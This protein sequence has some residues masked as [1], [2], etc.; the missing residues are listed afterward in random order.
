MPSSIR[1]A[2]RKTPWLE[3]FGVYYLDLFGKK[4]LAHHVFDLSDKEL[5]RRVNR[6]SLRGIVLS[7]LIGAICVWPTV[8][9]AVLREASGPSHS[10]ISNSPGSVG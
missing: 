8:Y 2:E 6:I 10:G 4:D 1:F 5:R 3:R 9:V 7:A